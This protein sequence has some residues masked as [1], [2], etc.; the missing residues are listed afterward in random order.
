MIATI[1]IKSHSFE[2]TQEIGVVSGRIKFIFTVIGVVVFGLIALQLFLAN[3]LATQGEVIVTLEKQI[4][5]IDFE[6]KTLKTQLAQDGAIA[7]I[8]Q[9][10]TEKGLEKPK[11][12]FFVRETFALSALNR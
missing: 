8:L 7:T 2:E 11:S 10:A 1:A 9:K 5:E 6:N 4:A 3:H 12:F